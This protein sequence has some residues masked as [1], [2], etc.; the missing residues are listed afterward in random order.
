MKIVYNNDYA[1]MPAFGICA[2]RKLQFDLEAQ[3][4]NTLAILWS[5]VTPINC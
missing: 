2:C 3:S 5:L 1:V 4:S